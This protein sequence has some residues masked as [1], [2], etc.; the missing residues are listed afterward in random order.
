LFRRRP[1]SVAS[2]IRSEMPRRSGAAT[3]VASSGGIPH[4]A[5]RS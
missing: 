2:G 3:R 1:L 4:R 5:M